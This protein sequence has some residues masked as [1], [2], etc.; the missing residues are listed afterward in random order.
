MRERGRFAERLQLLKAV[1]DNE[2]VGIGVLAG[3]EFRYVYANPIVERLAGRPVIDV[4]YAEVWAENAP[5]VVPRL[6]KVLDTGEAW[7]E[8]ES[9]WRMPR[10]PGGEP[11]LA[12]FNFEVMRYTLGESTF[13]LT[14]CVETTEES[15]VRSQRDRL[16]SQMHELLQSVTDS[17]AAIDDDFIVTYLNRSAALL[18]GRALADVVGT[19][20][21]ESIAGLAGEDARRSVTRAVRNRQRLTFTAEL[22]NGERTLEIRV[23]PLQSGAILYQTDVTERVRAERAQHQLM[24]MLR[25]ALLVLPD[26]VDGLEFDHR[27]REASDVERIG[28]DFY[29]LF[30]I[31][32]RRIGIVIGDVSE[33]GLKAAVTTALARNAIRAYAGEQLPPGEVLGRT[34]DLVFGSSDG[35]TFFSAFFGV[36][37]PARGSLEYCNAGHPPPVLKRASGET[38]LLRATAPVGGVF[39]GPPLGAC[40]ERMGRGDLLFTY[41]DGV[42]EARARGELFGEDRLLEALSRAPDLSPDR[43]TRSVIAYL[44]RFAGRHLTDDVAL[45]ALR[46]KPEKRA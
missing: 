23:F 33:K 12:Y 13:L 22:P 2:P 44:R 6:R 32:G 45:L 46:L 24:S 25:E 8:R 17:V 21:W 14:T 42:T 19:L 26:S 35:D 37:D 15:I 11:E 27:Y 9:P 10:T 38:V 31:A 4:P 20:C 40:V 28:G 1:L 7:I 5:V 43:A 39:R 18:S 3:P 36:L 34:S 16:L 29:D 41:T 30:S